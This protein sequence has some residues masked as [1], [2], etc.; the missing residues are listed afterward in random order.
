MYRIV[1]E[2]E[3]GFAVVSE[4]QI[5]QARRMI[6]DCEGL[7]P[8]FSA[9]AAVAGLIKVA[10]EST[11]MARATVVV[12]LTGGDR[13]EAAPAI[14]MEWISRTADG[15]TAPPPAALKAARTG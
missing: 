8:C 14:H 1:V 3:G 5:R 6:E 11:S 10:S 12:N 2:S 9:S 13:S 7:S 4:S 15:W